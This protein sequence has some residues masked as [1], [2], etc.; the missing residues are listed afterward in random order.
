MI[1]DITSSEQFK[2]IT[3][4]D[5]VSIV[6]FHAHWCGPCKVM[7]PTFIQLSEIYGKL[8]FYKLDVDEHA[9]LTQEAGA[10]VYPTF[11][12]YRK[13]AK[14]QAISGANPDGLAKL[15]KGVVDA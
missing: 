7:L 2:Q 8:K 6:D 11:I 3:S 5:A 13:G 14:V 1:T 4:Q 9:Q 12:V 15:I 10:R